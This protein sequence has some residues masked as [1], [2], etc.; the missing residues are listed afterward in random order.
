M[1]QLSILRMTS[2]V[3]NLSDSFQQVNPAEVLDSTGLEAQ[4]EDPIIGPWQ[5]CLT[6]FDDHPLPGGEG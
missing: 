4:K 2:M 3:R 6:R 5:R 1:F